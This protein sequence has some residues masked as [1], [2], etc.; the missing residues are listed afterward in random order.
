VSSLDLVISV[1]TTLVHLCGA[2]GHPCWVMVPHTAEWRYGATGRFMP[3]YSS[4]KLYR[5]TGGEDWK[6]T[7]AEVA[8]ELASIVGKRARTKS[9]LESLS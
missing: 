2:I 6:E 1:Q 7:V 8:S 9:R 3:W 4:V 5:Q